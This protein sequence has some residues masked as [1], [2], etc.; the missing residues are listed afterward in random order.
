MLIITSL[1]GLIVFAILL[2]F[3]CISVFY[4][5]AFLIRHLSL[6]SQADCIPT[7]HLVC[8]FRN[9]PQGPL[10]ARPKVRSDDV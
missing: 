9:Q 5:V 2:R 3:T 7:L 10:G 8:A 6:L 4:H 1:I